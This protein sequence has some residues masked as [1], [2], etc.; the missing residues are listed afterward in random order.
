MKLG[1]PKLSKGEV[2][3]QITG[4]RLKSNERA[5]LE[6]AA[7]NKDQKLSEW[8]RETLLKNAEQQLK[9]R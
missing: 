8:I 6:K 9:A 2:K 5:L 1:R 7:S 4:V 3:G